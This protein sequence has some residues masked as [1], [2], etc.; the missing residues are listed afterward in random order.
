MIK[1]QLYKPDTLQVIVKMQDLITQQVNISFSHKIFNVSLFVKPRILVNIQLQISFRELE[2]PWSRA[3]LPRK[4]MECRK[5][6]P[7]LRMGF[8]S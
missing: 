7:T 8:L 1:G 5:Q 4:R 3:G 6:S 2:R